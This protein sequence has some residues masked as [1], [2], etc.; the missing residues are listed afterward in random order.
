M[1][2]N[3]YEHKVQQSNSSMNWKGND[4]LTWCIQY[5][6]SIFYWVEISS[7]LKQNIGFLGCRCSLVGR[8]C[9]MRSAIPISQTLSQSC[10]KSSPGQIKSITPSMLV[11]GEMNLLQIQFKLCK[12]L[13]MQYW[14]IVVM[15]IFG[16]F[17]WFPVFFSTLSL[18]KAIYCV[19]LLPLAFFQRK[20]S[21][22]YVMAK[23][24]HLWYHFGQFESK[25]YFWA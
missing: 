14:V 25:S 19:I 17:W 15:T 18:N 12:T 21:T 13:V 9:R 1:H 22:N 8:V 5:P 20:K 24:A 3:L 4:K 7:R 6:A 2:Q 23:D 16:D 10:T 11:P